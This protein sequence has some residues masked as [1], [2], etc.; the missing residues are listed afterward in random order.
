MNIELLLNNMDENITKV[1]W[2]E[3]NPI[4]CVIKWSTGT[5][6]PMTLGHARYHIQNDD[7][8]FGV[9]GVVGG[10]TY[11]LMRTDGK[12][13]IPISEK[14][15]IVIKCETRNVNIENW[16]YVIEKPI[17]KNGEM[18]ARCFSHGSSTFINLKTGERVDFEANLYSATFS[19][20]GN[21]I[22]SCY[23]PRAGASI[24]HYLFDAT[25]I[26]NINLVFREDSDTSDYY[27]DE[28]SQF[29]SEYKYTFYSYGN[30]TTSSYEEIS[31]IVNKEKFN[32]AKT[33]ID[34]SDLWRAGV[35]IIDDENI[36][37][38]R[39]PDNTKATPFFKGK[40]DVK[41]DYP[42][43]A[44]RVKELEGEGRE[45]IKAHNITVSEYGGRCRDFYKQ[46]VNKYGKLCYIDEMKIVE[47]KASERFADLE[48]YI[49]WE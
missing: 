29:V 38:V 26:R 37:V 42:G 41:Y 30:T 40:G 8:D 13:N 45:W 46:F 3:S 12:E 22:Y 19:P 39:V 21:R 43:F 23:D 27:F 25:D 28:N 10:R 15:V 9:E 2:W 5:T 7:A 14:T 34:D 49:A 47:V 6:E 16:H 4:M 11:T 18:W 35:Q 17:I 20:N 36:S 24:Q 33:Y 48:K 44:E 31:D 32:G 1:I